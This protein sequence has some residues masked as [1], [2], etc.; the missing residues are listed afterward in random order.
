MPAAWFWHGEYQ[1]SWA[2]R[3]DGW[4][5]F[6]PNSTLWNFSRWHRGD[7]EDTRISG[8]V[9]VA[10]PEEWSP[11]GHV[12]EILNDLICLTGAGD[13]FEIGCGTGANFRA[14][15]CDRKFA[16]DASDHANSC[17]SPILRM[18]PEDFLASGREAADLIFV[19]FE[20]SAERFG[21]I[22]KLALQAVGEDGVLACDGLKDP[23]RWL[24]WTNL[25]ATSNGEVFIGVNCE[26]GIGLVFQHEAGKGRRDREEGRAR[27]LN[28]SGMNPE[29]LSPD[30]ARRAVFQILGGETFQHEGGERLSGSA[31]PGSVGMK[32]LRVGPARVN[33]AGCKTNRHGSP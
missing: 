8:R 27:I 30:E 6:S 29:W 14:I 1:P 28:L 19:Q 24:E 13:Y 10:P 2:M 20:G 7:V 3:I 21:Q 25:R 22:M 18:E 23:G 33:V 31:T 12:T 9:P 15:E 5:V 17:D 11:W 32:G 26:N 4:E 16:V